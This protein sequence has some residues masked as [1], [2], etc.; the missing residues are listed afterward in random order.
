[1]TL[2]TDGTIILAFVCSVRLT[3][4]TRCALYLHC[5]VQVIGAL[6]KLLSTA[7]AIYQSSYD[8][9][10]L[11]EGHGSHDGQQLL[12]TATP[13]QACTCH[14]IPASTASTTSSA[15]LQL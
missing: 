15:V 2:P 13:A 4:R 8:T 11:H 12:H 9:S 7:C 3:K 14:F 1:V 6:S 10:L 5:G